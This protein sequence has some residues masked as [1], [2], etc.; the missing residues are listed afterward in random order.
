M[1]KKPA[2]N[3]P[4]ETAV[5]KQPDLSE[6]LQ[7]EIDRQIGPLVSQNQRAQIVTRI[8][9]IMTS[10]VFSGPIAHPRHLREYEVILPGSA[11]RIVSMAEKAQTHNQAMES[12]IV[13]GTVFASQAQTFLGFLALMV[14]IGFAVYA[15]MNGNNVLAGLLLASGVLGGAATLIRGYANGSDKTK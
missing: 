12:K 11:E 4:S 2:L 9:Q 1:S 5:T 8:T 3:P 14:L 13:R 7:E 10:E 6:S 15:G